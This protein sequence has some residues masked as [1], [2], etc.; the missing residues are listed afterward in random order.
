MRLILVN[1]DHSSGGSLGRPRHELRG[2]EDAVYPIN[3]TGIPL[4]RFG[5]DSHLGYWAG[6]VLYLVS[7]TS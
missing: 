3:W 7:G 6:K 2:C 4:L 1:V 5:E